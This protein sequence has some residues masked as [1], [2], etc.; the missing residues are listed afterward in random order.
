[1]TSRARLLLL[2]FAGLLVGQASAHHNM[3]AVFDFNDRVTVTGTP[4]PLP[5]RTPHPSSTVAPSGAGGATERSQIE[6]PPPSFLRIRD[7]RKPDFE[8]SIRKTVTAEI[9]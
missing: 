2:M 1:M 6:A 8:A 9:S 4:P 3:S 7:V 5:W